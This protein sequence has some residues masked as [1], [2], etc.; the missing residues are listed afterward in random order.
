MLF[1][2]SYSFQNSISFQQCSGSYKTIFFEN[3]YL[4][5]LSIKVKVVIYHAESSKNY[6]IFFSFSFYGEAQSYNSLLFFL[7]REVFF[8]KI[9][10]WM[11]SVFSIGSSQM[12]VKIW[13]TVDEV[14]NGGV[15]RI[16]LLKFYTG[17]SFEFHSLNFSTFV[18]ILTAVSIEMFKETIHVSGR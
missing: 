17:I 12:Y 16:W 9:I 2:N 3:H 8:I 7:R 1:D 4:F 10:L 15:V 18:R 14:C 13:K 5:F 6:F 11:K